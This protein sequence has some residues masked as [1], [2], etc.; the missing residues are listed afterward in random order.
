MSR[1]SSKRTPAVKKKPQ[2][3]RQQKQEPGTA[4][5]PTKEQEDATLDQALE[6]SFPA[7]D[8]PARITP[9]RPGTAPN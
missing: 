1:H 5:A 8:P 7:S 2:P 4:A 6:D 3:E 9:S